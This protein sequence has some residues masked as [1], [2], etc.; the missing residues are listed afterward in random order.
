MQIVLKEKGF[1]RGEPDGVFGPQAGADRVPAAAGLAVERADRQSDRDGPR[2]LD[3][4]AGWRRRPPHQAAREREARKRDRAK[5]EVAVGERARR[6]Q[7]A[8]VRRAPGA[9]RTARQP[10]RK[11]VNENRGKEITPLGPWRRRQPEPAVS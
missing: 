11:P 9:C 5:A 4:A 6:R 10:E 8:A 2:H 7:N 1:Y 3:Q